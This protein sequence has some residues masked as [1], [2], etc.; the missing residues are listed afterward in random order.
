MYCTIGAETSAEFSWWSDRFQVAQMG[1]T[2][3]QCQNG[4]E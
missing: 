1:S 3:S 2:F 4:K